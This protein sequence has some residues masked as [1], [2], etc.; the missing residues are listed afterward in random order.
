M[1]WPRL[2]FSN[3]IP[4]FE[5]QLSADDTPSTRRQALRLGFINVKNSIIPSIKFG[6]I[7][8]ELAFFNIEVCLSIGGQAFTK[9]F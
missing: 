3:L 9:K 4:V 6:A 5:T 1:I 2:R 8:R 7:V